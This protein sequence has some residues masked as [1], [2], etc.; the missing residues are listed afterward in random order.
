MPYI[1][2]SRSVRSQDAI[3]RGLLI[4]SQLPAW[5][6][7]AVESGAVIPCEWHHTGK[8]FSKTNYYDPADF[9][10]LKPKDFPVVRKK[11]EWDGKWKVLVSAHWE[12]TSS[13]PHKKGLDV[14]LQK[15][16]TS[17]QMEAKKYYM[18]G[19][20]IERFDSF[21]EA[22]AYAME[23]VPKFLD[24][25]PTVK[26]TPEEKMSRK[27]YQSGKKWIQ[28]HP[29][30]KKKL[31]EILKNPDAQEKQAMSEMEAFLADE[32]PDASWDEVR[33]YMSEVILLERSID[34]KSRQRA[35]RRTKKEVAA[36]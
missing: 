23:I 8:F 12:G 19:G 35:K 31:Y 32:F 22:L 16:P 17:R 27:K 29:S 14:S 33:L 28:G 7:R 20:H 6:K 18:Y 24:I 2:K 1:G 26:I 9:E 34:E 11:S 10:G 5:Q 21:D 13:H 25:P 3:N 30:A 15:M 36:C 4:K